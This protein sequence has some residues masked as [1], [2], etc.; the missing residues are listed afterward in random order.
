[1]H[2]D[3]LAQTFTQMFLCR[4]CNFYGRCILSMVTTHT[5]RQTLFTSSGWTHYP[6]PA[7]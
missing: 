2:R 1:M 3:K 6:S 5:N 4:F 7:K